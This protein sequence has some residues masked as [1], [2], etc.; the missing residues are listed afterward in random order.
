MRMRILAISIRMRFLSGKVMDAEV[1]AGE[2]RLDPFRSDLSQV[3]KKYIGET[4]KNLKR[5]LMETFNQP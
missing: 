4:E 3:V 5:V 1:L 2:L